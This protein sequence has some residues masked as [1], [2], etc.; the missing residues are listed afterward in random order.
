MEKPL[1]ES[2]DPT[3]GVY[4]L[5]ALIPKCG[6]ILP[7]MSPHPRG[8]PM[9]AFTPPL[10]GQTYSQ[11]QQE[12]VRCFFHVLWIFLRKGTIFLSDFEILVHFQAVI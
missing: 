10:T 9:K 4:H 5:P 7:Q 2:R 6:F 1:N 3:V 12:Y 8:E 11:S